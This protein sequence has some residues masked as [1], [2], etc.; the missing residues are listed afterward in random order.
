MHEALTLA[1]SYD[2]RLQESVE[3]QIAL[4]GR[5]NHVTPML[6]D[7]LLNHPLELDVLTGAA[8]ELAKLNGVAAGSILELDAF[9]RMLDRGLRTHHPD[10]EAMV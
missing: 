3:E 5:S 2:V 9:A 6:R 8:L 4:L 7:V 1:A 10:G